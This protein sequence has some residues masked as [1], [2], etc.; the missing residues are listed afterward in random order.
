MFGRVV[1]IVAALVML[2]GC[3]QKPKPV[4]IPTPGHSAVKYNSAGDIIRDGGRCASGAGG[5]SCTDKNG[6]HWYCQ[7]GS[8]CVRI[9]D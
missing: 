8:S 6:G 5:Q 2:D 3:R 7:T 9:D 4:K 1:M